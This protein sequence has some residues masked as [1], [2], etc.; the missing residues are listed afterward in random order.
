[1]KGKKIVEVG[2]AAIIAL[3]GVA[4][5]AAPAFA[6]P[7]VIYPN[8]QSHTKDSDTFT[9]PKKSRLLVVSNEKTL[10]NEVLLR[11]LKRASSQLADRGVLA[12]APQIVFGTLENAADNDIIVKMA[13]REIACNVHFKP[14]P[15]MTAYK[16][17]GFDIEDYPNAYK[18]YVNEITLPLHTKLSDEDVAYVIENFTEILKEYL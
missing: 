5:A 17:L 16:T 1:M 18:H 3:S 14:L 13:E 11:D 7:D 12:E 2:L 4:S 6:A 9:L 8:V 10:N 15:M